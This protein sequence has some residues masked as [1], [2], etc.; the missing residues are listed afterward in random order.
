MEEMNFLNGPCQV[1]PATEEITTDRYGYVKLRIP[2]TGTA[3]E[4][5]E[6]ISIPGLLTTTAEKNPDNI[7]YI[8]KNLEGKPVEVTYK[9]YL[10]KIR[11]CAK[12]FIHLG[13][14]PRHGVAIIGF[15]SPEWIISNMATIFAGGISTGIYATN[16]PEACLHCAQL[17]KANVIVVEDEKQYEKIEQIREK[18]PLLKAVVQYS[19]TPKNS[20]VL[21]WDKLMEIGAKQD[22]TLLDNALKRIA[23]NQCCTLIFTSGTVGNPKAVMLSHDNLVFDSRS[24]F[25]RI[26]IGPKEVL[27]SYLPFSHVAAQIID[28]YVATTA[29]ATLYF[30]DKDA[31]K[32]SLLKTLQ[33]ARPTKFIAVPRVWEKIQ[34]K[35]LHIG[36]QSGFLKK[37]IASWAK[38]HALEYH[39]K[40][41]QGETSS[42]WGYSIASSLILSKVK[43]A[44]GLDRCD[45]FVSAAAPISMDVKKYF[46]SLDIPLMDAFGMSESSGA[47]CLGIP[48]A[49]NLDTVGGPIPGVKTKI[50]AN[51]EED[52]GEI[53]MYGRH[54]FMGYLDEPEK[55]KET[56]DSEGWL[57]SG[58]LGRQDDKGFLYITGRLKELLIT[59]GGENVPPV[60]IE[61]M[62]QS[63]LPN[64]S[65][66]MLI[67]DK[68][69]FLSLLIALKTEVDPSTGAPTAVLTPAVQNWLKSLGC[70]ATTIDEVL[71]AGPD[72]KL[73]DAIQ[74]GINKVNEKA[75]S[76]AQKIQKF[77]LLPSDF[78]VATGELGPTMK[79]KRRIVIEKYK[80]LVDSMY[81]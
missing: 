65:Y 30:A 26:N 33:E 20:D 63:Q 35:M 13:L 62:V 53:C 70:P 75:T 49:F 79:L 17:S 43:Q 69:K 11:D 14:E 74:E 54:V 48:S 73:L 64:I 38:A 57:H 32:G 77:K 3:V 81:S 2:K 37:S 72:Q 61:H 15:N 28:M 22:D 1:V 12:A 9:E 23:I 80:H 45:L 39:L 59:A 50:V 71:N 7:A 40:K 47:H 52:Q 16:S 34:E 78:S 10:Q 41:I 5:V 8:Y 29:A 76:N 25:E 46:L 36:S 51:A 56:L 60:P 55:T 42:S 19:G 67:G 21:T 68:K 24:I 66:A 44:L 27:V 18:L 6:P 58:D 31:L 4:T